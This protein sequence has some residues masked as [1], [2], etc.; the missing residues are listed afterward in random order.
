MTFPRRNI[1]LAEE[2]YLGER[3][4]FLTLCCEGRRPLFRNP[5]TVSRLLEIL[6]EEAERKK[7]SVHAYCF[8]PDH[9][10]LLI[11][12]TAAG[13]HLLKF[14]NIFKQRSGFEHKQKT[15]VALWQFK[16]YDHILRRREN[17]ER[18]EGYIWMN[19]VRKGMVREPWDY[20]FSGSLTVP[21]KE[22]PPPADSWVPPWKKEQ[23]GERE[24]AKMPEKEEMPG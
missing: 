15:G 7:F 23:S 16:Y 19:P 18:I 13:S 3:V 6:T 2:N 11:E 5:Q 22:C 14:V 1:R 9:L 10:H 8:M 4:Y 20:P 17:M 21:W 12:G 24:K